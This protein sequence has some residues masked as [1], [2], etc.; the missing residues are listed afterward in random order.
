MG[1]ISFEDKHYKKEEFVYYP[2]KEPQKRMKYCS[3]FYYLWRTCK[4]EETSHSLYEKFIRYFNKLCTERR[5][6]KKTITW[7]DFKKLSLRTS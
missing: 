1:D 4:G 6:E 7:D 5:K 2:S 3:A